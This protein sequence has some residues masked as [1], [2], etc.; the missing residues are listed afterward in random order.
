ML[1]IDEQLI[2]QTLVKLGSWAGQS[3]SYLKSE[4][5][6]LDF[7]LTRL[8]FDQV[9]VFTLVNVYVDLLVFTR[10]AGTS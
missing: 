10:I 4:T 7:P 6:K 2:F 8:N 1:Y 5:A 3:E 9:N